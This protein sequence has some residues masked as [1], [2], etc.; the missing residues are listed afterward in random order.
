ARILHVAP[1]QRDLVR[2][3][4]GGFE[5]EVELHPTIDQLGELGA[6]AGVRQGDADLDFLRVRSGDAEGE[7]DGGDRKGALDHESFPPE[8]SNSLCLVR[9]S[10]AR[11]SGKNAK[12]RK[13]ERRSVT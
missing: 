5:L 3:H 6:Y 13:T 2:L 10:M 8:S 1:D 11:Y 9:H 7:R 4:L 12:R